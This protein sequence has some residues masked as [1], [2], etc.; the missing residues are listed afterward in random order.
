MGM[1]MSLSPRCEIDVHLSCRVC[2]ARVGDSDQNATLFIGVREFRVNAE[3][4]LKLFIRARENKKLDPL[5]FCPSCVQ[6]N[7][8]PKD[9]NYR[10]RAWRYIK[11]NH[12]T[13]IEKEKSMTD[14][15]VIIVRSMNSTPEE[16]VSERLAPLLKDGYKVITAS[17]AMSPFGEMG[18]ADFDRVALH[19]YFVTTVVLRKDA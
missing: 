1:G 18:S 15:K 5:E 2:G 3:T 16:E 14:S 4:W 17:T 12:A 6:D 10:R 11:K 13:A 19:V 7:H 9:R 8:D